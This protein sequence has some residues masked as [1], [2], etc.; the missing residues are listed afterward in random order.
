M[1]TNT[2]CMVD[3]K[4]KFREEKGMDVYVIEGTSGS[5][6]N[7]YVKWLEQQLSSDNPNQQREL[8]I[9]TLICTIDSLL[10]EDHLIRLSNSYR[11][12]K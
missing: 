2:L 12:L 5:F 7:V 10:P 1:C 9:T 3:I 11:K 6:S 4:Q 8:L